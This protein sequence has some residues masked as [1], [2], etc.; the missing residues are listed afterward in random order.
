MP[1]LTP[2][3]EEA[4]KHFQ[5]PALTLSIPGSGKTT[6]LIHRLIY[7][8]ENHGVKPENIL[9]LTFSKA[10]AV[11]MSRRYDQLFSSLHPYQFQFMT[12]HR[13]AFTILRQYL[14][15]T[16]QEMT[17]LENPRQKFAIISE[18]YKSFSHELLTEDLYEN[19]TNAFG[20]YYNLKLSEKEAEAE[21]QYLPYAYVLFKAFHK[22]K[23]KHHLYDF[24][25]MLL[26]ALKILE[27]NPSALLFYQNQ[28]PFIQVDE[29]QDTS[30]LQ[31]ELIEKLAS[32]RQNLFLVADDDQ[33]I[34]GF[35][36]A[37]PEYLLAFPKRFSNAKCYYLKD[38][39]RS[40][41]HIVETASE[42]IQENKLRYE[43]RIEPTRPAVNPLKVHYFD[44]L[45]DRNAFLL[46]SMSSEK[47]TRAILYRN[48]I[49]ALSLIATLE[50]NF[51]IK[52]PPIQEFSH[53]ILEDIKA[54]MTFA[55]IP[56]DLEAF[57]RIAF[58]TNGFISRE[59]ILS[60]QSQY[61]T[62]NIMDR[63]I[64]LPYL[65]DYQTRTLE[66]LKAKFEML[67]RLRPYDAI[68]FIETEIGYL[69][70]LRQ[71]SERL[72][73]TMNAIRT[74]IDAY[75]A[76][77]KL[78]TSTV[79]FFTHLDQ[80]QEKLKQMALNPSDVF[81][82]TIHGAK[83]LEFDSV[84]IIDI[85]AGTFPPD[86]K[87]TLEEERRLFYVA[88]TRAKD[89]LHLCHVAF[90]NGSMNESSRFVESVLSQN[91]TKTFSNFVRPKTSTR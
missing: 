76:I 39:F 23:K 53:W 81:L 65:E 45:F 20:R 25:D 59:M 69:D 48:K 77:G 15:K 30:K 29:A 38:N 52:D 42:I 43:K 24:D 31:F 32:P 51:Y 70:Y 16:G 19:Y 55:M 56:Q 62:R 78:N 64:E 13:F 91:S 79:G 12:I 21:S 85:N 49:S 1:Q 87:D 9:T 44:D 41:A 84:Y 72:G 7:L 35:R 57:R 67:A 86:N 5:G 89:H 18:L 71:H 8:A 66:G 3:Q 36:G 2:N 28:Y 58:K 4:A 22:Y 60:L 90:V 54:F 46:D 88:L 26:Y 82:S 73:Y 80:L 17:L 83:G 33:S 14:Q 11:D 10:A 68:H 63:L 34:Y 27:Q 75:K 47:G 74:R 6:L 50:D 40:D 61:S 37:Y